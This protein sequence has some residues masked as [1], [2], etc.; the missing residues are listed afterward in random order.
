M[1]VES[2]NEHTTV[3]ALDIDPRTRSITSQ[4]FTI[5]LDL[6][7]VFST[8]S[9]ALQAEPKLALKAVNGA[10]GEERVYT[11]DFL[12]KL[13]KPTSL[14][15]ECKSSIEISNIT[16]AL[17]RRRLVL[18]GLGFDY[19]VVS[20][21]EVDHKGL[22]S[23][24]VHMR[25][26]ML[27]RNKNNVASILDGLTNLVIHRNSTFAYGE[28]RSQTSDLAFYLG[29][30]SGVL[31]CDLRGG[32]LGINTLIWQAHGDLAHLQLLKLEC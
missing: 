8:R 17:A 28:I 31:G 29:L 30:I 22:H 12:V 4:P 9:H 6:E 16:A 18:N 11:P 21:T 5:R 27:F 15:V 32:H 13:T 20:S 23:N 25:D 3:L 10:P 1:F 24:L 7:R 19:L 2:T 26:A 14:V